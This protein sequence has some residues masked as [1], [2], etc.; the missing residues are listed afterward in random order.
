MLVVTRVWNVVAGRGGISHDA[1]YRATLIVK[2]AVVGVS[3]VSAALHTLARSMMGLA[4]FGALAGASAL[5]SR[6]VP[7][8]PAG[9]LILLGPNTPSSR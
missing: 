8:R 7:R 2:I 3:G 9:R 6:A 5:A 1:G 4:V